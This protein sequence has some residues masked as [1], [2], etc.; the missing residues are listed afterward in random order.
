VA[1]RVDLAGLGTRDGHQGCH[2]GRYRCPMQ[3]LVAE[4]LAAWR[5]AERLAA[6]LPADHPDRAGA[7]VAAE[8]LRA[9]YQD[10]TSRND[11]RRPTSGDVR[12]TLDALAPSERT[13][14][15]PAS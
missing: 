8:R 14:E 7:L 9:L 13:T 1:D 5:H 3:S 15:S 11:D 10:L 6:E 12:A 4:V 2:P